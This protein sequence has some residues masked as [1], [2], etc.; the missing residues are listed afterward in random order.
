MSRVT[1]TRYPRPIRRNNVSKWGDSPSQMQEP[2][3]I[4]Q[5][6]KWHPLVYYKQPRPPL[7]TINRGWTWHSGGIKEK[8]STSYNINY[9]TLRRSDRRSSFRRSTW[10]NELLSDV[11]G[12]RQHLKEV[13]IIQQFEK[14]T[15]EAPRILEKLRRENQ[16]NA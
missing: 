15:I 12:D 2:I 4:C 13:Y 6:S 3:T 9:I 8:S 1:M 16:E 14:Y 5:V 7:I 11:L 10:N